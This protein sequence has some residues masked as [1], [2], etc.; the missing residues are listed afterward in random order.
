MA[1]IKSKVLGLYVLDQADA[2]TD[3]YIVGNG[4]D[5]NAAAANAFANGAVA[6]DKVLLTNGTAFLG[7]YTLGGTQGSPTTTEITDFR[8]ALAA[9]STTMDIS[10]SVNEIVARDGQGGSETYI[11]SGAQTWSLS[12]DGFLTD[13][14][15]DMSHNIW[16]SSSGSK[17]VICKFD[18]DVT[19]NTSQNYV[20]QG[21]IES[22]SLSGGFDDNVTY[23]FTVNG[24]GKIYTYAG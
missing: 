18:T 9:T 16:L 23:S 20:G 19:D 22:F 15:N 5:V 10:N 21:L 6:N 7:M 4:A 24:Y 8:L 1:I 2:Q 12:G 3:P 17:Y 14:T 13:S 11:V